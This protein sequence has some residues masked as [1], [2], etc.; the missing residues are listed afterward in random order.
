MDTKKI[1]RNSF[2]Y[3]LFLFFSSF[4]RGLVEVFSLVLLYKKGYSVDA[5]FF[6]L[7]LLY[8]VGIFVNVGSLL[9]PYRLVLIFSTLLYGGS[10]FYLSVMKNTY[11][12]LILFSILLSCSNYSYHC[13]R[14]YLACCMLDRKH[15][16]TNRLVLMMYLGVI[17]S[18]LVGTFFVSKLPIIYSGII[19]FLFSMV[20]I[21]PVFLGKIQIEEKRRKIKIPRLSRNKIL[22]S[23]FEQF[24]V[25]FLEIQ[26]LFLYL[27]VKKS[28][29]YVGIF[30]VV[31]HLS[32]LLVVYFFSKKLKEKHFFWISF[33]IALVFFLKLNLKNE[34]ILLFIALLEGIGVKMY[35]VF[36]LN[37]LYDFKKLDVRSYLLMEEVIFFGTKSIFMAIVCLFRFSIYWVLLICIIGVLISGF[38]L[39]EKKYL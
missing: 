20:S 7:F 2:F 23:I 25:M 27:Y 37:N 18:S 15:L 4:T 3:H 21:I 6:F 30:H 29:F 26:P 9:L 13:V 8:F 28:I 5:L 39:Q 34:F 17:F 38:F 32:S 11:L 33:G 1:E 14:H 10:F 24:K 35:E 16:Q 31:I 19:V 22:F 12:S 36:S